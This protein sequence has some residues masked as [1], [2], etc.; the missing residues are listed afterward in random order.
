M[1]KHKYSSE[2]KQKMAWTADTE[3]SNMKTAGSESVESFTKVLYKC[4]I[5]PI[6]NKPNL[7]IVFCCWMHVQ[8]NT[9]NNANNWIMNDQYYCIEQQTFW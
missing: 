5:Y 6:H 4:Y 9:S 1:D 8:N 2:K 3:Y 7:P